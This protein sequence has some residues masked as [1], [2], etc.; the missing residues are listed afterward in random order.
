MNRCSCKKWKGEGGKGVEEERRIL[1]H[2]RNS[3]WRIQLHQHTGIINIDAHSNDSGQWWISGGIAPSSQYVHE[4]IRVHRDDQRE[5]ERE[6]L[7]SA[8]ISPPCP[9]YTVCSSN[10]STCAFEAEKRMYDGGW[11]GGSACEPS[12]DHPEL[13]PSEPVW[14]AGRLILFVSQNMLEVWSYS[15]NTLP[16]LIS[17]SLFSPLL[18]FRTHKSQCAQTHANTRVCY[19][20]LTRFLSISAFFLRQWRTISSRDWCG[21]ETLINMFSLSVPVVLSKRTRT[22]LGSTL[23]KCVIYFCWKDVCVS[24][25]FWAIQPMLPHTIAT[26]RSNT[27]VPLYILRIACFT[28]NLLLQNHIIFPPCLEC[29]HNNCHNRLEEKR[30]RTE[31]KIRERNERE[32]VSWLI[33]H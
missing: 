26:I 27:A 18:V 7:L 2:D 16:L 19:S 10:M 15:I 6:R 12:C 9:L 33:P 4:P 14:V 3:S 29:S 21:T 30:T 17:H 5:S 31:G 8:L 23:N 32:S 1:H 24:V 28:T 11:G 22:C 25:C 20:S 13:G